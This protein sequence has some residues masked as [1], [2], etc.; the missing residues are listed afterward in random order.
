MRIA[1]LQILPVGHGTRC[2]S[3]VYVGET[4]RELRERM[5]EHL[6]DVRRQKEKNT[7][8]RFNEEHTQND[9][10]FVVLKK[11]YSADRIERQLREGLDQ[12]ASDSS[13]RWL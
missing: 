9:V 13:T 7:K 2:K 3:T 6:R 8:Y 5:S 1:L 4:E 11:L 10:A 12:E